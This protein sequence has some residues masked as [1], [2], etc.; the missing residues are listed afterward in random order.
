[1]LDN[2]QG[3]YQR[4]R[5]LIAQGRTRIAHFTCA[6]PLPVFR[7]HQRGYA[8]ALRAQCLP[9]D[10]RLVRAGDLTLAAGRQ[11]MLAILAG[12]V[13]PDAVFAS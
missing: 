6:Q 1:M 9:L 11:H 3:A 10:E 13:I 2:C 12:P 4:V 7:D 8:E 5:H